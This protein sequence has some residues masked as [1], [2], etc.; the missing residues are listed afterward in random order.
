M[1]KFSL[2]MML[3]VS[4]IS[5]AYADTTDVFC[6]TSDGSHWEWL[7]DDSGNQ[8]DVSGKWGIAPLSNRRYFFRYFNI[9][10]SDYL[11]L[12]TKCQSDFSSDYLAQPADHR[13]NGWYVF[14]ATKANGGHYY[15]GGKYDSYT[16]SQAENNFQLRVRVSRP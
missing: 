2:A 14:R 13:F 4:S 12:N 1:T 9:A 7:K 6:A 8:I 10:E 15:T 11:Q 5:N 3:T 16:K